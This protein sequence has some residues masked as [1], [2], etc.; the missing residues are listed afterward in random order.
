ECL[1]IVQAA[2]A[3]PVAAVSLVDRSNGKTHFTVPF[4][5][6]LE[7]SFPTFAADALPPEL[8]TIP[9]SKPGS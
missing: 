5:A 3:V 6:L 7:L 4:I 8:A 1:D 2:G 9:A